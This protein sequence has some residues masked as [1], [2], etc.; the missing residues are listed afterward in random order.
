MTLYRAYRTPTLVALSLLAVAAALVDL[1]GWWSWSSASAQL[2]ISPDRGAVRLAEDR[3][4]EL[5][6]AIQR[7]RRLPVRELGSAPI[8]LAFAVLMCRGVD[9]RRWM[10]AH[11]AGSTNLARGYLLA[12]DLEAA[13]PVLDDALVR[14]PTNAYLHRLRALILMARGEISSALENLAVAQALAP[15]QREPELELTPENERAVRLRGLEL[16]RDLYPRR[17]IQTGLALARELRRGG[18][19]EGALVILMENE[20]HPEVLLERAGWAVDAGDLE[21]ASVLLETVTDQRSAPRSLRARAWAMTAIT[22][23]LDGDQAGAVEAAFQALHLDQNS[24]YAFVSLAGLAERR[25]DYDEAL[26]H[27]RRA[28]GMSPSDVGL[29]VR[30]ARVAERAGKT[31]DAVLAMERA[32]EINPASPELAVQLVSLQLRLGDFTSAAMT[33]SEALD[34]HPT[35]PSLLAQADRLRRDV[36]IR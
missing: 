6:S 28:W 23:D 17:R 14:D 2:A 21:T 15:D 8:D 11:A 10:P 5:P 7:S 22:R 27:L 3:L 18:D 13:V 35:D 25:G 1:I 32:V 36:G 33:L 24:P 34:R 19:I 26:E 30:I 16:Q 29:L 20:D 31:P 12:G 4:L 9:Q